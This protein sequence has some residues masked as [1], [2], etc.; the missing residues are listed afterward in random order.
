M[1]H[2]FG[3]CVYS[4]LDQNFDFRIRSDHQKISYECRAYES[5]EVMS[6]FK[7]HSHKSTE[8]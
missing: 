4:T 8:S 5:V 3:T 6:L 7:V 1:A 2:L